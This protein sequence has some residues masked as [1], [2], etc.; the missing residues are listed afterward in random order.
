VQVKTAPRFNRTTNN[1]FQVQSEGDDKRISQN[2]AKNA[3][4]STGL[5][6]LKIYLILTSCN[7]G[8]ELPVADTGTSTGLVAHSGTGYA[9]TYV[10]FLIL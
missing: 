6:F 5:E 8:Q 1:F 7:I 9:D 2:C 4:S 10:V 3:S